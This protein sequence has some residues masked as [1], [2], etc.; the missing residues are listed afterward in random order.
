MLEKKQVFYPFVCS[1]T[2]VFRARSAGRGVR[3]TRR[4][5]VAQVKSQLVTTSFTPFILPHVIRRRS[6]H[7]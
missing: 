5:N 6:P 1:Q 4:I 2:L 7:E 3:D